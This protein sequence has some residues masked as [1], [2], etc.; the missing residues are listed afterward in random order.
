MLGS[1]QAW[2]VRQKRLLGAVVPHPSH[3]FHPSHTLYGHE[4]NSLDRKTLC[5]ELLQGVFPTFRCF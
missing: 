1:G 4:V 2:G 5:E 3:L